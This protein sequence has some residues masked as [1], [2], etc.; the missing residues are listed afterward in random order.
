MTHNTIWMVTL[1]VA[2]FCGF[3]NG[4]IAYIDVRV[5][6]DTALKITGAQWFALAWAALLLSLALSNARIKEILDS[7]KEL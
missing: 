4:F 6:A 7:E 5:S 3:F 1:S 2:V